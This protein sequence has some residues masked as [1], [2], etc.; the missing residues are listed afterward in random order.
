M[1]NK[2]PGNL[3]WNESHLIYW[4]MDLSE[5][6]ERTTNNFLLVTII[7]Q[8]KDITEK[9]FWIQLY[10]HSLLIYL[11]FLWIYDQKYW[12]QTSSIWCSQLCGERKRRHSEASI[13]AN[14]FSLISDLA[15]F[16]FPAP[17]P[18]TSWHIILTFLFHSC[19][20]IIVVTILMITVL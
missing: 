13:S 11:R 6:S 12:F 14:G 3:F 17:T 1:I 10:T 2:S 8:R 20:L 19:L 18:G 16:S 7:L 5:G 4:R 9:Q 15:K